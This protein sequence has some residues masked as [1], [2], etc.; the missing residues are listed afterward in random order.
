MA[1]AANAIPKVFIS[2]SWDN[3]VHKT[4][5]KDL[6][7]KLRGHGVDVTLDRWK[8]APGDTMPA[9]METAVRENDYVLVVCTP[10]YKHRSDN[11]KGGVGYEGDIMTGEVFTGVRRR[12]FIPLLKEGEWTDSAPSW[13]A[14]AYHLNFTGN[15]YSSEAYED[16]L[17][18]LFGTREQAPPLGKRPARPGGVQIHAQ[19]T[20]TPPPPAAPAQNPPTGPIK[21]TGIVVD[22]IGKPR[23]DGT[24]GSALYRVPFS[25]SRT[26][27]SIWANHFVQTWNHPPSY[28]M[29]HRPGIA[30]VVGSQIILNG[31]TVDEVEKVHR[32]TLAVVLDKVNR[33][34]AEHEAQESQTTAAREE[35]E[36]QERAA[37]E[38]A[39][40][41]LKFD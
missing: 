41:R 25:L 20:F 21:I 2:Y 5:V 4:W 37:R 1:N 40:K 23:N 35:L 19:G 33:E 39:A 34:V 7:S 6:A 15:P 8:L 16:L 18:T 12:K 28:T 27:S 9:F 29:M 31:T 13:L 3:E 14:P 22:E 26:P 24:A 10:N 30:S 17:N 36:R 11:R 38:A 32:A